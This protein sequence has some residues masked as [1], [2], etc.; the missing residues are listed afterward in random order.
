MSKFEKGRSGNPAGRPPG[1]KSAPNLIRDLLRDGVVTEDDL[2][3][4]VAAVLAKAKEGDLAAATLLLDRTIPKLR[5]A[6]DAAEEEEIAAARARGALSAGFG[7]STLEDLVAGSLSM[8][9]MTKPTELPAASQYAP[10]VLPTQVSAATTPAVP[11]QPIRITVPAAPDGDPG[12]P[13]NP[14]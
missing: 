14:L 12:E 8:V 13:Y 5:P 2:R 11:A 7:G 9:V 1:T 6:V 4:V 3:A 10:A